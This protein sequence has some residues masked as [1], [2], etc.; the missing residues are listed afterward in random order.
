MLSQKTNVNLNGIPLKPYKSHSFFVINDSRWAVLSLAYTLA[1]FHTKT[2]GSISLG[3]GIT[4]MVPPL[5]DLTRSSSIY[6]NPGIKAPDPTTKIEEYNRLDRSSPRLVVV[7]D[8]S[9]GSEANRMDVA[10]A[11]S[12]E[13]ILATVSSSS[14]D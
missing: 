6:P 9:A 7:M 8:E 13:G 12:R 14:Y 11:Y 4:P 2:P 5:S 10:T 3:G 1:P